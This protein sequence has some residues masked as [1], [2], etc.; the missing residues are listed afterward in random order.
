MKKIFFITLLFILIANPVLAQWNDCP[1]GEVYC[2]GQCGRFI[3]TDND[4]YCDHSQPAPE[5]RVGEDSIVKQD[6]ENTQQ[7]VD[8]DLISGQDLKTK[9]VAEIADI[10]EINA[11]DLAKALSDYY[12]VKIKQSDDFQL[13]HDNYGLEP[14]VVKDIATGLR[15][16]NSELIEEAQE[17]SG[18]ERKYIFFP[19]AILLIILYITTYI[20]SRKNII[21]VV[22][23]R[24]F[25]NVL[26]LLTFLGTGLSGI[27]LVLRINLGLNIRWPFNLLYWHVEI[28]LAMTLI[29]IFHTLWHWPYYKSIIKFKSKKNNINN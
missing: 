16:G 17:K 12:N 22:N 4:G 14:S 28:G 23:Q 21:S 27:F 15:L 9:T 24:K 20:L 19:V 1:F 29:S 11:K 5:D 3:D 8:F 6:D 25:W 26:L 10:Y 7:D 13:M 2:D 18:K